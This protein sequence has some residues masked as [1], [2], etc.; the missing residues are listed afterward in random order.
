M[1]LALSHGTNA[2]ATALEGSDPST[3]ERE[4]ET[5]EKRGV[6]RK[7]TERLEALASGAILQR[8]HQ[9][10]ADPKTPRRVVDHE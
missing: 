9:R 3:D 6:V 8:G 5:D 4:T 1:S 2:L 7:G 10:S